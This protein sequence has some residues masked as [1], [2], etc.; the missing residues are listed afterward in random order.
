MES[1]EN[2]RRKRTICHLLQPFVTD[3]CYRHLLQTFV[4]D[5]CYSHL[6]QTFVT[7]IRYRHLLQAFVTGI[8]Y[9]Q[10]NRDYN[11]IYTTYK[12]WNCIDNC[13]EFVKSIFLDSGFL[14][15]QNWIISV[16]NHSI[17]H[18]NTKFNAETKIEASNRHIFLSFG[19]SLL[20]HP[21]WVTLYI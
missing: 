19:S 17:H 5:I 7:G 14:V 1:S 15:G 20:S 13:T 21:L 18:Q 8:G 16:L 2:A 10:T 6:L 3:I 4:T 9:R 12:G 11:F